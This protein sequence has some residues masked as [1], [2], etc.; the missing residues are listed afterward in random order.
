MT[1][2]TASG[3][4]TPAWSSTAIAELLD[5][6]RCPVCGSGV[7][8]E[9]RCP[10]CGADFRGAIG[11]DLWAASQDA[12]DALRVRQAVLD[13]V[14]IAPIAAAVKTP[15]PSAAPSA[16]V[17][18]PPPAVAGASRPGPSATVQSV[19]AV[20]GAGLVAVAAVVFTFFNPDLAD[21]LP[22]AAIVGGI[23][24]A[25]LG[26]SALLARRGLRFS[27]EAI[28]ALGVVFLA[29]TIATALALLPP[30]LDGWVF[31]ALSTLVAGGALA[32]LGPRAGIRAWLWSG[33]VALAFVPLML[34]LATPSALAA[35]AG[36]LASAAA[37]SALVAFASRGS[38]GFARPLTAEVVTLTVVQFGFAAAALVTVWA[39]DAST[40]V[41]PA[42]LASATLVTIAGLAA[43]SARHLA[44]ALWSGLAGG[45]IVASAAVL[46]LASAT[47]GY[48]LA[49]FPVAAGLGLVVA[50]ALSPLH[51]MIARGAF[52]AG[53]VAV[54]AA[55]A[56]IP[57]LTALLTLGGV[58]A[59]PRTV[60]V[61]ATGLGLT[62]GLAAL[63]LSLASFAAI[64]TPHGVAVTAATRDEA[65]V[66]PAHRFGAD[67]A[68]SGRAPY[69][70]NAPDAPRIPDAGTVEP[71]RPSAI[72]TRWLGFLGAWYAV[73]AFLTV[74]AL[75]DLG[76]WA[77]I[78][79]GLVA[80]VIAGTV[81]TTRL[82]DAPA[83]VRMPLVVGAHAAVV[84][85]AVLSWRDDD[86]TVWAGAAVVA[87][88][89]VLALTVPRAARFVHVG[90]G[91]AYA[92]VMVATALARAGADPLVVVCLTTCAAG[93]VAIAVTFARRV[94]S[95]EWYAVLVVTAVPFAIG[96]LQVVFERSGWTALSTAV[97]FCLALTLVTTTRPGLGIVVRTLAAATLVPAVAV[98]AVCLG[99]QLLPMS[100]SPIVLPVIAAIVAGVLASA[101]LLAAALSRRL[102]AAHVRAAG[103]AVEASALLTA[104][105]AVGLSLV[106][107][108]AGLPTTLLVLV[109]LGIGFV[110]TA[111]FSPR[112]YAWPLAGAAFTGALWSAW[113]LVGVTGLE[114]YLL[115]P[116]LGVAVVAAWLTAR[117]RPAAG[118]YTVG[119]AVAVVPVLIALALDG[120]DAATPALAI[121]AG[122]PARAYALVG[123][124]WA[125]V[126][127]SVVVSRASAPR[128]RRLRVLR[129]PTLAV[130]IVAAAAAAVQGVR[131]GTGLDAAP[132]DP[133][134]VAALVFG[135]VGGGAAACAAR[136]LHRG[137]TPETLIAHTR[138]LG[139]PAVLIVGIAT[140]PA[141]ERDWSVIWT[142]WALLLALLTLMVGV[143]ARGLR[144]PTALPPVWFLFAVSFTTA[145]VAWSP[146][147]LRVEWFSLPLGLF[148]LAAG[149]LALRRPAPFAR[150]RSLQAWPAGWTG[151]W[152]LLAPGLITMLSA[153]VAATYTDPRTWRAILV[154]AIALVAILVGAT[155]RL[156]A[157]FLIGIVVLPV[158]NVLAFMVQIGR[159][160]EA[161][162]WW[163]TLSVVG[164]VLLIIA[165]GYE[166][167]AGDG[168]G[169][170]ARLRDLA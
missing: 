159:G 117:G 14:P 18:A 136:S 90:V 135:L 62:A 97:I 168:T 6:V 2:A 61:S 43:A 170:A 50:G 71:W 140:W 42:Y 23:A 162:P 15:A 152:P 35:T 150:A 101:D 109:I 17:A 129:A 104:V 154:M 118:L 26:G 48:W 87:T 56:V 125:L 131:W 164:A 160:I 141:I 114:P 146:R 82:R 120:T 91:F 99:A 32:V 8:A 106:R 49:A 156:A 80:A 89:G 133:L 93:A 39:A 138:W 84:F 75:A 25:F 70:P 95:R 76:V 139:A 9:R 4:A 121:D 122:F 166:R 148:L 86:L 96:V 54:V 167:R 68:P 60:L 100:G 13:R 113:G 132:T 128:V 37:A 3:R 46:P 73:L 151:S 72:G 10:A 83:A 40:G 30:G 63:A 144:A 58:I 52:F 7:V 149:A 67:A 44:G 108:S 153:S 145:V 107:T 20:A 66:P 57:T 143:A 74:L 41:S 116:A 92:L 85:A 29:L 69:A 65:S 163:I 5:V 110:A 169:L 34:G 105:I 81:S 134:I 1:A 137:A 31:T 16:P 157:P 158:E 103:L 130:A 155:R 36:C 59:S 88:L 78:A 19:L 147:D 53:A 161:M 124:A 111:L 79:L 51:R 28:G 102:P 77:R 11:R 112:H 22:R 27:A 123:A 98:V 33:L 127:A 165:V 126:A 45:A 115:P 21:P 38:A 55:V 64:T 12:V 119:L 142:M 24:A 47:G 94:P